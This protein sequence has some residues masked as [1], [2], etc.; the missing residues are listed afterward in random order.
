[1]NLIRNG[2]FELG[3]T[4]FWRVTTSGS[5]EIE[6]SEVHSGSY[7]GKF[8]SGGDYIEYILNND[9]IPVSPYNLISV[10]GWIKSSSNSEV[11]MIIFLYDSE[12]SFIDALYGISRE[13]NGSYIQLNM[14]KSLS[15]D[16]SYVQIGYRVKDS[17]ST[18]IFYIDSTNVS[19][20]DQESCIF[21]R[22]C[23]RDY[24]KATSSGDTTEDKKDFKQFTT[25]YADLMCKNAYGSSKTLDVSVYELDYTEKPVLLGN[26]TQLTGAGRE[27]IVLSNVIGN[28]LYIEYTISGTNPQFYFSVYVSGKR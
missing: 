26:F 16:V 11:S 10:N 7:A 2:G 28:Q 4:N 14:Q 22:L 6:T 23:L 8:I 18:E 24:G 19:I 12:Y 13:T 25:Y 5:L 9:Y 20:I 15:N 21:G 3:N 1:M 27:R 17:S